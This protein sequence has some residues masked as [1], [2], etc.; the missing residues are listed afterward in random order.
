MLNTLYKGPKEMSGRW[1]RR[2]VPRTSILNMSTKRISVVIFSVLVHQMCV[3]DNK[4]LVIAY[5][6]SLGETSYKRPK[7]VPK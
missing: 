6:S 5:F 2:D 7:N 1:R 3:S 4:K